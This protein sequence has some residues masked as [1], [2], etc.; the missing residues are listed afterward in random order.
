MHTKTLSDIAHLYG[1][2]LA[3]YQTVN[4]STKKITELEKKL[5]ELGENPYAKQK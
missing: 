5:I 3:L 4:F 2:L 1:Q